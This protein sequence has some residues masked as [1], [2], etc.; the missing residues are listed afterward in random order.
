L[1]FLFASLHSIHPMSIGLRLS[2]LLALLCFPVLGL[3]IRAPLPTRL[4]NTEWKLQL[5]IGRETGTW[6]PTAW[7][8][9]GARLAFEVGVQF[10][11]EPPRKT[12]PRGWGESMLGAAEST[13][14]LVVTRAPSFVGSAGLVTVQ[15]ADGACCCTPTAE[16]DA[17]ALRMFIDFPDGASRNDVDLAAGERVFFTTGAWSAGA[18]ESLLS[19]REELEAALAANRLQQVCVSIPDKR[20]SIYEY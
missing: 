2:T 3:A 20:V 8:A 12:G 14:R 17:G 16:G 15:T 1:A 18:L 7:G 5:N 6:M 10:L 9:S 13:K 19:E 4:A 11:D